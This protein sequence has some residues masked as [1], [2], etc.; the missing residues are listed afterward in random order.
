MPARTMAYKPGMQFNSETNGLQ[1]QREDLAPPPVMMNDLNNNTMGVYSGTEGGFWNQFKSGIGLNA[2]ATSQQIYQ[3]Y[4]VQDIQNHQNAE[5]EDEQKA[6][7][8][9]ALEAENEWADMHDTPLC[10]PNED[11]TI[12][13]GRG[14]ARYFTFIRAMIVFNIVLTLISLISVIP[15]IIEGLDREATEQQLGFPQVL[16][17]SSYSEKNFGVW[18][19][20]NVL[21]LIAMLLLGPLY[22]MYVVHLQSR[23]RDG[24]VEDPFQGNYN[25]EAAD[26]VDKIE[27]KGANGFFQENGRP[28]HRSLRLTI[29]LTL[30]IGILAGQG[31]LIAWLQGLLDGEGNETTA[32]ILATVI[33][34]VAIVFKF[35]CQKLTTI[36]GHAYISQFRQWE[37]FKVFVFKVANVCV[38]YYV[39]RRTQ[40]EGDGCLLEAMSYQF[41]YLLLMDIAINGALGVAFPIV[42]N[43]IKAKNAETSEQGN[44]ASLPQFILSDDYTEA[45]YKQFIVCLGFWVS[46]LLPAVG[47]IGF[48]I[49]YWL[50]KYRLLKL[51]QKPQRTGASFKEVLA[52]FMF[53]NFLVCF[54]TYPN[55]AVWIMAG[56]GGLADKCHFYN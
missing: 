41:F 55:G 47:I 10:I 15:H 35:V 40:F 26:C 22:R 13:L 36:E 17:L 54:L 18:I 27:Y 1:K 53:F 8:A 12:K 16:Y 2:L 4:N 24:Y 51:T 42:M 32:L 33:K 6:K 19:A 23:D 44:A 21:A 49:E 29:S 14:F 5:L 45:A 31:F 38:L 28:K 39:T 43:K 50:D 34:L 37:C 25:I 30:F 11:L 7:D 52:F 46:P 20:S 9:E 56:S 3:T 48:L